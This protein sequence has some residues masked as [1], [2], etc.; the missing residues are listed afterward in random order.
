MEPNLNIPEKGNIY[1]INESNKTIWIDPHP[2]KTLEH[3]IGDFIGE[4]YTTRWVGSLVADAHRTLIKGGF[5]C[6][7]GLLDNRQGKL[8][9]LYE[10][11]P[12]AFIFKA[13]GGFATDGSQNILN[14]PFPENIHQKTP[15]I[16]CGKFEYDIFI[17]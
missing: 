7:P 17:K 6:Y 13:A 15:T 2:D 8:R 12:F 5:F 11:Y 14:I 1:S 9:L 3:I 4:N 16:L 10:V